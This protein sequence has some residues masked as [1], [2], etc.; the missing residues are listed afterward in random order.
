MERNDIVRLA[1][2]AYHGNV[3]NFSVDETM[4]TLR[5]ALVAANGGSTK[6]DYKAVRDGR[7]VGVFSIIED[8]ITKTVE[9]GLTGNEYFNQ[10]VEYKNIAL[11]DTNLFV[12]EDDTAFSVD[13]IAPGTQGLRRQRLA[14]VSTMT[15]P[16]KLYG[17]KIYEELDRILAGHVDFNTMIRKVS[18][19]F[20]KKLMDEIFS[21]WLGVT[22]NDIGG[23]AYFQAVSAGGSYS[24]DT[25]LDIIAHVEA[26]TGAAATIVGTKKALRVLEPSVDSQQAWNDMYNNGYYGKFYGTPVVAVNQR[27][28][29]G[30][31]N[32]LL[33]DNIITVIASNAD[34]PIKVVFEGDTTIVMGDPMTNPDFSQEYFMSQRWGV[35]LL[36]TGKGAGIGRYVLS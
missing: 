13:E 3:Q 17:V 12:V 30:T 9:E 33:P 22:A 20:D 36:T 31:T 23:S 16:T 2:D 4:D 21:I 27:H 8:I 6:L 34:K 10:F 29:T 19:A 11:G 28:A 25:L 18:E 15:V 14:G 24:E 7:A 1:L 35:N 32:F 26:N 5:Q